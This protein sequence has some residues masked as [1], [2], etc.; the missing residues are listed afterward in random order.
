MFQKLKVF[1]TSARFVIPTLILLP[2]VFLII[3][4]VSGPYAVSDK[5]GKAFENAIYALPNDTK[6]VDLRDL[7]P[8]EWDY[9]YS[10][11]PYTSPEQI[12]K[13]I[14]F[15]SGEFEYANADYI[16]IQLYFVKGKEIVAKSFGE[17]SKLKF[18]FSFGIST[19]GYLRLKNSDNPVFDVKVRDGTRWFS[20]AEE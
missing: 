20:I 12:E 10:F 4:F 3:V 18:D 2:I 8:F 6:Q 13:A 5:N 17:I 16:N 9:V 14:G 19:S 7:T 1:F 11:G 15:Y